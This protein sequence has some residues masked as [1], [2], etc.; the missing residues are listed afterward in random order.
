MNKKNIKKIFIR[1]LLVLLILAVVAIIAVLVTNQHVKSTAKKNI[2]T[3]E[4]LPRDTEFDCILILGCGVYPNGQPSPMLED[5]LKRGVE[6]Y[7][8]GVAPKILM[9]GDHGQ[10][11][12]DEVNAMRDYAINQGIPPEDIFMDHAGF[13][14][15]DSMYRARDVFCAKKIVIVT[16]KYHLY[17]AVYIA[18][19]LGLEATGTDS[20][21]RQ[22]VGQIYL[23]IREVAARCKDFLTCIFKPEPTFLG[24]AIP[25]IGSGLLTVD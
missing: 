23:D 3:L 14:T 19:K 12:Y 8:N 1:T 10:A 4:E 22:Y 7:K 21:Y 18:N 25:V 13:S 24:E 16:Q 2:F 9:S 6:L 17:R 15:Y 20:D 5:R 11:G